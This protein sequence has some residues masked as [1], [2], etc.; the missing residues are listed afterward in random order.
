MKFLLFPNCN[1]MFEEIDGRS[2]YYAKLL[3][4]ELSYPNYRSKRNLEILQRVA[5]ICKEIKTFKLSGS[6]CKTK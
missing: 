1:E 5:V 3:N 2:F 4:E 6:F